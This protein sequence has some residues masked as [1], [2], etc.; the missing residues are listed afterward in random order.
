MY[1]NIH[2]IKLMEVNKVL[3]YYNESIQKMPL[4]LME[5]S[6]MPFVFFFY[7]INGAFQVGF[8]LGQATRGQKKNIP[9]SLYQSFR[10][11]FVRKYKLM[12]G[13]VVQ[14]LPWGCLYYLKGS[15]S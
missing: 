1:V 7:Q 15:R 5:K 12:Q 3:K 4:R 6:V 14:C 2:C 9:E 8:C 10:A 13:H 11:H